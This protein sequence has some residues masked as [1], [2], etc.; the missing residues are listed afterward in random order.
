MCFPIQYAVTWPDRVANSFRPLDLAAL[1]RL[2]FEAPRRTDF[3][4]LD[5]A[6]RA[7]EVGGSLPAAL[8]AANEVAVQAFLEHHIKF[9][10]IWEIVERVMDVC[11]CVMHPCLDELADIDRNARELASQAVSAA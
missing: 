7:G 8:N 6:R 10:Q 4:A 5:L 2:D 1:G 11:P 3:P 9:P